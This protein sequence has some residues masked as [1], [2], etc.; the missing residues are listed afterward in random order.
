MVKSFIYIIIL[1]QYC[2]CM[3]FMFYYLCKSVCMHHK[4]TLPSIF[5]NYYTVNSDIQGGPK[6]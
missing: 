4:I 2:N 6:K 3:N 1:C 5:D